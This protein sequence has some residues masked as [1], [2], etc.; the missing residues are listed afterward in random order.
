[1]APYTP[2][3]RG[4]EYYSPPNI[5]DTGTPKGQEVRNWVAETAQPGTSARAMGGRRLGSLPRPPAGHNQTPAS[6]VWFNPGSNRWGWGDGGLRCQVLNLPSSVQVFKVHFSKTAASTARLGQE[7]AAV[8]AG[9][10][11]LSSLFHHSPT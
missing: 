11:L 2:G 5:G 10:G 7:F 1:M 3:A 6:T 4:V 8:P 9:R